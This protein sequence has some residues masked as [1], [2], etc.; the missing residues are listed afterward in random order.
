MPRESVTSMHGIARALNE[1]GVPTAT[2]KGQWEIP[3]V[4]W[5][6]GMGSETLTHSDVSTSKDLS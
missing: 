6:L 2:G 5:V 3:P 4:R 1:R